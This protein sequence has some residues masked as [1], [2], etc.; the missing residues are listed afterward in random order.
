[1]T[2]QHMADLVQGSLMLGCASQGSNGSA[3][4]QEPQACATLLPC[5]VQQLDDLQRL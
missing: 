5:S 2:I 1:M 3:P 4:H